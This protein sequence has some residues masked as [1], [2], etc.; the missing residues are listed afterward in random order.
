[1]GLDEGTPVVENYGG[2]APYRFNGRIKQV[3]VELKEMK[4]ADKHEEEKVR[5]ELAHKKALSD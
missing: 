4:A 5:M 3:T 1:M 2:P